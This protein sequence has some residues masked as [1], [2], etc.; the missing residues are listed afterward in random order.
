[1]SKLYRGLKSISLS[2]LDKNCTKSEIGYWLGKEFEG[3]GLISMS[4]P[5]ILDYAKNT[6]HLK[7][8]ELST[9]VPNLRSQKLPKKFGFHKVKIIPNIETL[10]DG[11][12]DHI[13]WQYDFDNKIGQVNNE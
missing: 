9:S 12:V 8:V 5:F 7:F 2:P 3:K 1:M 10:S 13:L 6:L 11:P 4:F